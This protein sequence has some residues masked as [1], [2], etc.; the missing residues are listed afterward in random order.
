LSSAELELLLKRLVLEQVDHD[1]YR[2]WSLPVMP[3][4]IY[5]GQTLAQA[6]WAVQQ[7]QENDQ[8]LHSIHCYFLLL[9]NPEDP[10]EYR[11]ER[12]R[13]GKSFSNRSVTAEQNQRPIFTMSSSFHRREKGPI[14]QHD[15]PQVPGPEN[16]PSDESRY[17][18][19]RNWKGFW[20][21]EFRTV[22]PEDLVNPVSIPA[23]SHV[24]FKAAGELPDDPNLHQAVFAYASDSPILKTAMRPH[25]I[26]ETTPGVQVATV[27]HAIWFHRPFRMDEWLLFVSECDNTHGARGFV[28]AC[29]YNR[30][31]TLVASVTQEGLIRHQTS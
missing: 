12:L 23:V 19:I 26:N 6:V 18:Q 17:A 28:R 5:G 14:H 31:G 3:N 24:W 15:M 21:V 30:D 16:L 11:V 1:H 27:D 10:V 9:G 25:A 8:T 22:D 20:P 2:G 13:D 7:S 29:V 4:R